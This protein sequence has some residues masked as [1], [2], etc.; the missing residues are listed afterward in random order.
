MAKLLMRLRKKAATYA[1]EFGPDGDAITNS[2]SNGNTK[3]DVD[4]VVELYENYIIPLTIEV[5]VEYLIQRLN[6]LSEAEVEELVK[7]KPN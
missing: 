2:L 6:G 5:E 1:Q 7:T 3:V 4:G